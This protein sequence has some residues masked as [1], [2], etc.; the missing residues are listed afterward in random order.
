MRRPI[1]SQIR[2]HTRLRSTSGVWHIVAVVR[3]LLAT[4]LKSWH[5]RQRALRIPGHQK[6]HCCT[7]NLFRNDPDAIAT[8][9]GEWSARDLRTVFR[10]I[11]RP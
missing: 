11:R 7:R 9:R 6:V 8:N 3:G 2:M 5:D 1:R 4:R 10:R